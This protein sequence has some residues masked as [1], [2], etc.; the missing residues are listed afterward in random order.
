MLLLALLPVLALFQ[1]R[2]IGQVSDAAKQRAKA[3]LEASLDSFVTEFDSEIT[4]AHF[5]FEYLTAP[6]DLPSWRRL[7]ERYQEW[8]RLAP[9]PQLVRE[10]YLLESQGNTWALRRAAPKAD[11]APLSVWPP[12]LEQIR[13]MLAAPTRAEPFGFRFFP[14]QDLTVGK[15]DALAIPFVRMTGSGPQTRPEFSGWTVI[16]LDSDYLER[17]FLPSLLRRQS[18]ESARAEFDIAVTSWD[19]KHVFFESANL[20]SHRAAQTPDA[21]VDLFQFRPNCFLPQGAGREETRG[22]GGMFRSRMDMKDILTRKPSPCVSPGQNAGSR[23]A[24]W[25]LLARHRAG[26][27]DMAVATFRRRVMAISFG[28]LLVLGFG[29][30]MLAISTERARTLARRQMEFATGVSHELRTPLTVI[31]VA[32]DNLTHGM[33]ENPQQARKY[34]SLIGNEARRLSAMVEQILLF[35][36][37]QAPGAGCKLAPTDPGQV[38]RQA[39]HACA[40][41]IQDSRMAVEQHIEA[42]LPL[43]SADARLLSDCLQNLLSNAVKYAAAGGWTGIRAESLPAAKPACVRIVVEDRGPGIPDD[44]LPHIFEPFYRGENGKSANV[45]GIGMG[46]SIVKSIVDAHGGRIE[47]APGREGGACFQLTFPALAPQHQPVE[48]RAEVAT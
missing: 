8:T 12:G 28:V 18:L 40:A 23:R 17:D 45:K 27:L 34:G 30:T 19:G 35:A 24:R 43:I 11:P 47:V 41:L 33:I 10:L 42:D 2:W 25:K 48:S 4:R 31:R 29:I 37:S 15:D 46:L 22:M 16:V 14:G 1:Y 6:Q 7:E 36:G 44:D 26:S 13:S 20:G 21:S 5:A 3:R 38:V 9:Y 32:A 39:V